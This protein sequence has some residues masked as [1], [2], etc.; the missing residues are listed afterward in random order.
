MTIDLSKSFLQVP[1]GWRECT[2][3]K[4]SADLISLFSSTRGGFM[5]YAYIAGSWV[6]EIVERGER[7]GWKGSDIVRAWLNRSLEFQFEWNQHFLPTPLY[8]QMN[9][10]FAFI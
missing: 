1:F 9:R 8:T 10:I 5:F 2:S 4:C 7:G 6:E 3:L